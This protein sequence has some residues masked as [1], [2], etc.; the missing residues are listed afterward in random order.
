MKRLI[1]CIALAGM[2][3]ITSSIATAQNWV[4]WHFCGVITTECGG[5]TVLPPGTEFQIRCDVNY[6][7]PSDDDPICPD[8]FTTCES[9]TMAGVPGCEVYL[10][11]VGINT[12]GF[13]AVFYLWLELPAEVLYSNMMPA[14]DEIVVYDLTFDCVERTPQLPA[15]QNLTILPIEPGLLLQWDTVEAAN[16]YRIESGFESDSFVEI[17]AT[18]VDT[19]FVDSTSLTIYSRRFYRIVALGE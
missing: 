17:L 11:G 14:F 7:G 16:H 8:Y 3:Q 4:E 10:E 9:A 2:V 12:S 18:T 13:P 5:D 1:G 15:P 6:N 19:S